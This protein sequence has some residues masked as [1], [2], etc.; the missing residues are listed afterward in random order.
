MAPEEEKM[1]ES[2]TALL[3][4]I[5]HTHITRLPCTNTVMW[6]IDVVTVLYKYANFRNGQLCMYVTKLT[7]TLSYL[8]L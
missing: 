6:Y 5:T 4:V 8:L 7:L 3:V 2:E 1:T